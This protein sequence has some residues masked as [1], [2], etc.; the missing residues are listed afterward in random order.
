[1]PKAQRERMSLEEMLK[2][3]KGGKRKPAKKKKKKKAKKKESRAEEMDRGV[4][5]SALLIKRRESK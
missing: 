2:I 3:N 5:G 1:M 4:L